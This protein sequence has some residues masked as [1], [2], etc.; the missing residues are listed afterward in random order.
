MASKK[1]L[2]RKTK[3]E[4]IDM[5]VASGQPEVEDQAVEQ[6]EEAVAF[7]V[8]ASND[9][10]ASAVRLREEAERLAQEANAMAVAYTKGPTR[11]DL[12]YFLHVFDE[13]KRER[14]AHQEV[15]RRLKG[16]IKA[17][18]DQVLDQHEQQ[19]RVTAAVD[20]VM[21][22]AVARVAEAVAKRRETQFDAERTESAIRAALD[23]VDWAQE[24]SYEE[25]DYLD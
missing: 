10:K 8:K 23:G 1:E 5:I 22:G 19:S 18:E 13:M 7:F 24:L 11:Q 2:S 25:D 21:S 12:R 20:R 9:A 17:L 4:L 14:D 15:V 6:A 3:A 16:K